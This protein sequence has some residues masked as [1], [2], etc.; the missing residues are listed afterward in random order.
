[1]AGKDRRWNLKRNCQR[2]YDQ[3]EHSDFGVVTPA[4]RTPSSFFLESY[5][6]FGLGLVL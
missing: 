4:Y 3:A 2:M 6:Y 5:T 1:M